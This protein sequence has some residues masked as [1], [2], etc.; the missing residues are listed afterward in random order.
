VDRCSKQKQLWCIIFSFVNLAGKSL[1]YLFHQNLR[2]LQ[3]KKFLK[4]ENKM[5]TSRENGEPGSEERT[6]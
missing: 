2:K 4:K 1:Y 5:N 3:E 6:N